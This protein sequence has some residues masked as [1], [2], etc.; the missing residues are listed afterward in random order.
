MKNKLA[1][2]IGRSLSRVLNIKESDIMILSNEEKYYEQTM[3]YKVTEDIQKVFLLMKKLNNRGIQDKTLGTTEHC[4]VSFVKTLNLIIHDIVNSI[5]S[6]SLQYI[7][8]GPEPVKTSRIFKGLIDR[9]KNVCC[10]VGIDINPASKDV[11]EY[12]ITRFLPRDKIV[13]YNIL[14][15][16]LINVK[17]NSSSA[18][19]LM[20]MLGFE[21]GNEYP[22]S[23][24]RIL[25][26][27]LKTG[28]LFLSEMQLLPKGDWSPIFSFYKDEMREFSRLTLQ[29]A[30]PN[31][32]S[33]YGVLLIP[34]DIENFGEVMI[35]VTAE[36]VLNCSELSNKIFITNYCIKYTK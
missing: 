6:K 15:E 29:R 1:L 35:A 34:I 18:V 19:N 3:P 21:E 8:L 4:N 36:K 27:T 22:C 5:N 20:T 24:Q 23:I 9:S 25:E 16:D 32:Q 7:E 28:D 17:L 2:Q 12:E 26:D 11:M 31:V 10:Y 13:F 30:Y 33:D 14:F